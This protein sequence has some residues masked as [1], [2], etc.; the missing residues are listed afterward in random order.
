MRAAWMDETIG[1]VQEL[2]T[3]GIPVV[4]YTWFPLFSMFDWA[5]RRGRRPRE[6]YLIHLGLYELVFD[7]NG[8]LERTAT[9]LVARYQNHILHEA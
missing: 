1:A 9:P 4:G 6:K 5:Y 3:A 2:R 8:R 7:G